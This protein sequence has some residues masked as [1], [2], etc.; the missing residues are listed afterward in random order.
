[1]NPWW[2]EGKQYVLK[3]LGIG[4]NSAHVHLGL[5]FF[6][7]SFW[8]M[9]KRRHGPWIAIG[10]VVALQGINE[11]LDALDWLGWTGAIH[12][13]EAGADTLQTLFWPVVIATIVYRQ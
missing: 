1:M 11:G 6:L 12:W 8:L 3:G 5:A 9:R 4:S 10:V 2:H 13:Q 7:L